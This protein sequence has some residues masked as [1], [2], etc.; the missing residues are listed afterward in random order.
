MWVYF[1]FRGQFCNG[2]SSKKKGVQN[3]HTGK[4]STKGRAKRKD[5]TVHEPSHAS[6]DWVTPKTNSSLAGGESSKRRATKNSNTKTMSKGKRKA[7]KPDSS[8]ILHT[9]ANWMEPKDA[10]RR[11]VQAKGKSVGLAI[12]T[13]FV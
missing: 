12:E 8:E 1:D 6:G 7:N 11:R 13:S 3:G 5:V 10:G 2:E 9:S 4:N